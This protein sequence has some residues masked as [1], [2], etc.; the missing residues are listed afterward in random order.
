MI[1]SKL[2][3]TLSC[4]FACFMTSLVH[5]DAANDEAGNPFRVIVA[6]NV[7]RLRPIP[8]PET[9]PSERPPPPAPLAQV[10]LTGIHT[11][12]GPPQALFEVIETASGKPVTNRPILSEGEGEGPI[13]VL[14]ID[15]QRSLV[16]IRNGTV[17]T[18]LTFDPLKTLAPVVA[19]TQRLPAVN[20]PL[21]PILPPAQG[22]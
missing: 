15:V 19:A 3:L 21:L 16:R 2:I 11:V 17:E 13:H 20:R 1:G 4:V 9:K 14:A 22:G 12:F 6:S 5:A 8:P 18:N 7:F 10:M